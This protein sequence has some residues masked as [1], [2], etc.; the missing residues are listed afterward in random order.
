MVTRHR[1]RRVARDL[2]HLVQ[3]HRVD[4]IRE[5][6]GRLSSPPSSG[7]RRFRF[8]SASD[9]VITKLRIGL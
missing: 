8:S 4:L 1:R 2:P 3:R 6:T 9:V 7:A 5:V